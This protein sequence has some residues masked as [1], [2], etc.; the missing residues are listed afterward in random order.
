[1]PS[2]ALELR[3]ST[4]VWNGVSH[5]AFSASSCTI[6]LLTAALSALTRQFLLIRHK[7]RHQCD[8]AAPRI[9]AVNGTAGLRAEHRQLDDIAGAFVFV[10]LSEDRLQVDLAAALFTSEAPKFPL[11]T[12]HNSILFLILEQTTFQSQIKKAHI[13]G[14]NCCVRVF[15]EEYATH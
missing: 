2:K 3:C 15:V 12:G 9:Q 14:F 10:F 8:V 4:W 13:E 5:K 1:M 11:Q 6:W 7:R